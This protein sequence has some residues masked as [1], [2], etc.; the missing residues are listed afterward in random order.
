M[1]SFMKIIP[2]QNGEN[3]L[4]FIDV[5][6]SCQSRFLNVANM[7]FNAIRKNEILAKI[8]ESTVLKG[9]IT[10]W[11]IIISHDCMFLLCECEQARFWKDYKNL[12]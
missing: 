2:S 8:S 1:R 3:S 11:Q 12:S 6:K 10:K 4:P 7:S 5:G 9:N